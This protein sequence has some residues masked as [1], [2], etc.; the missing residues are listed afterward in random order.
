MTTAIIGRY[1]AQINNQE[2]IL[3]WSLISGAILLLLLGGYGLFAHRILGGFILAAD[4][5][6]T[7]R[8]IKMM[9]KKR[10]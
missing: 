7:F 4:V 5:W 6:F 9:R 10:K 3:L 8:I 1:F 2:K